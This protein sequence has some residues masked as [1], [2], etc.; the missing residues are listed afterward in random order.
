MISGSALTYKQERFASDLCRWYHIKSLNLFKL[1][2]LMSCT[3]KSESTEIWEVCPSPCNSRAAL[4]KVQCRIS[5]SAFLQIWWQCQHLYTRYLHS[6]HSWLSPEAA[7][8]SAHASRG[9]S[10]V[11]EATWAGQAKAE[12]GVNSTPSHHS[13][14]AEI[15]HRKCINSSLTISVQ[16]DA[17]VLHT[18]AALVS[19]R[20]RCEK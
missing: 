1:W 9:C 18:S 16:I 13:P 17:T 12:I 3:H 10:A 8:R 15:P 19:F 7:L 11:C 6:W 5:V 14:K 4:H 20:K 2:V